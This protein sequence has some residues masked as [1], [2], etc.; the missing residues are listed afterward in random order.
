MDGQSHPADTSGTWLLLRG[1]TLVDDGGVRRGDV[2]IHGER[3][4]AVAPQLEANHADQIDASGAYVIPGGIDVHTHLDLPVGDVRSADDFPS[5][6][7]AAACGGTTALIDFAGSGRETVEGAL[8]AWHRKAATGAFIDYGFHLTLTS[9][10][11]DPAEIRRSFEWMVSQ[12]VTSVKLYMAYPDRLMVDDDT[13][14][15][16]LMTAARTGVL[17]CVHAEDGAEIVRLTAIA[18]EEG[19]RHPGGIR[20]ARPPRVEASA[21]TRV[22]A[23]ARAAGAPIYVV[24]LSSEVGSKAAEDARAS[25]SDVILE[26]CPQYLFLTGDELEDDIERSANFVCTPPLREAED[27]LA[28]RAG[29]GSGGVSVLATDHCPFTSHDRLLGMGDRE[30]DRADFTAIPGGLPGVETRLALAYQGVREGWLSL[31]RWVDATSGAPARLF[32]LSHVKGS[33]TPGL[34]AD[35]VVFDPEAH[36]TL[37]PHDLHMRS[38][39]SPYEDLEIRGW[40]ALT[41]SR[42]R[43]V[44]KGGEPADISPDWG[45]YM[46][47]R[48]RAP[49]VGS[50]AS[51]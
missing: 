2:L 42:G 1:G 19:L 45:R 4:V 17:T 51:G 15:R 47:R 37:A 22:A 26:T 24:H 34:D 30:S 50:S 13:L 7:L 35:V 38:D 43:M 9:L 11:D 28:L 49:T 33:L 6:T 46:H 31:D 40:P 3:I 32:G 36:R 41:I 5:G 27:L 10:P 39:H 48:P 16:A 8:E 29:L 44:A 20:Q 25:G 21:I 18:I 12:G 14:L 23:L